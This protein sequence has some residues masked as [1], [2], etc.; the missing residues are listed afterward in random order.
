MFEQDVANK[1]RCSCESYRDHKR[2]RFVGIVKAGLLCISWSGSSKTQLGFGN[3]RLR[4]FNQGNDCPSA[5]FLSPFQII[6]LR[7]GTGELA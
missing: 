3:I 1:A 7:A 6:A 5:F 2:G 4:L